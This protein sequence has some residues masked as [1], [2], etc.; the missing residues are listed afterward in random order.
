[1]LVFPD[2][3]Q[4]GFPVSQLRSLMLGKAETDTPRVYHREL[5]VCRPFP[6]DFHQGRDV[7]P[8]TSVR[9]GSVEPSRYGT[10]QVL[11]H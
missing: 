10:P 4:M 5:K 9:S 11:T 3:A 7:P 6:A 2:W 8:P 1:M